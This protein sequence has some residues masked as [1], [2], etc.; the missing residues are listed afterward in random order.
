MLV[1]QRGGGRRGW[2]KVATLFVSGE[3]YS[4][5]GVCRDCWW[6]CSARRSSSSSSSSSFSYSCIVLIFLLPL[7]LL[8]LLTMTYRCFCVFSFVVFLVKFLLLYCYCPSLYSEDGTA[9]A[10]GNIVD[11]KSRPIAPI[12]LSHTHGQ[13]HKSWSL[14][15][16]MWLQWCRLQCWRPKSGNRPRS[17]WL[18]LTM[19][20]QK[21]PH[22]ISLNTPVNVT[23][24]RGT[25]PW[26]CPSGH[27]ICQRI[28]VSV[29]DEHSVSFYRQVVAN[30]AVSKFF[31]SL[32]G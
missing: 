24:T 17:R 19:T 30:Q 2:A 10:G 4:I 27:P 25:G 7:H 21:R 11:Y 6:W 22:F 26:R 3:Y 23:P 31:S 32:A 28:C 13:V 16:M 5:I 1:S 8:L 20:M 18:H 15:A 9:F 14:R 12:Q 29:C